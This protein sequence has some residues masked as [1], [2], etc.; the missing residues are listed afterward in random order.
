MPLSQQF[1]ILLGWVSIPKKLVENVEKCLNVFSRTKE[2][3]CIMSIKNIKTTAI[4]NLNFFYYEHFQIK[5]LTKKIFIEA[6][7]IPL[8]WKKDNT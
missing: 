3:G 6:S 1:R 4:E 7:F 5:T 8:E 2:K